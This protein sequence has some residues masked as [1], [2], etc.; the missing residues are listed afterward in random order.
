M[1]AQDLVNYVQTFNHHVVDALAT[2]SG[3]G[4]EPPAILTHPSDLSEGARERI[5][6]L[7]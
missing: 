2:E 5:R 6:L 1:L 3:P 7:A 4:N